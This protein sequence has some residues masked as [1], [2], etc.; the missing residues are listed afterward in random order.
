MKRIKAKDIEVIVYE[1][2]LNQPLFLNSTVLNDLAEFK[3]KSSLI[4]ANRR[5]SD[6]EDVEQR[7]FT[8]DIFGVDD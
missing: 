5:T 3:Q 7:V 4:I 1:P 2:S 6:L 8:R